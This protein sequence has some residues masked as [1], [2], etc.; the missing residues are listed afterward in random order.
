MNLDR[1]LPEAHFPRKVFEQHLK[2]VITSIKNSIPTI[3]DRN[4]KIGT[5][6]FQWQYCGPSDWVSSFWTGQ[7]WLAYK[8]TGESTFK[9]S[10]QL[11]KPYFK[12][13]LAL[14]NC[15][16]HDLG[17]QYSLSCVADYKL[18]LDEDSR[19]MALDAADSLLTRFR[20]VGKYFV[21]WNE[22]HI[23]G[24]EKTQ[25][26]S[27]IDSLENMALLFWATETTNN[28]IYR[29]A[30]IAHADTLA[31]HIVRDDFSTFHTFD[32]DPLT[33]EP[34]C[35][36]TFQGYADDS[37]WARGQAWAIHGYAQI[38]EYTGDQRYLE[39]AKKLAEFAIHHLP[40]NG[41]PIWDY[42][43]PADEIQYLDSSAGAVTAA[44]M[45]L[46]AQH[47][48]DSEEADYFRQWGFH[49]L[50][51]LMQHCDLTETPEALGLL[52][53]GASFV[54]RGMCKNMLP[55]GDYY[56]MEALMRASGYTKFFW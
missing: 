49:M 17:F 56:Y 25:G 35:G 19:K 51:G 31:K 16:D 44:G 45:L 38:F 46:I 54:K 12:E 42:R 20:R 48:T 47:C 37:C 50:A 39:L 34:V 2:K 41:V 55:Y 24:L 15:H 30:A 23:L 43:L 8:L 7:L 52:S 10:A 11:R 14:R 1:K 40:E 27:I 32:F 5:E 6:D 28:P 22:T 53:D 21:A 4:P 29:E 9:N 36:R 13:L 18:N 3:G 33:Q 26:K